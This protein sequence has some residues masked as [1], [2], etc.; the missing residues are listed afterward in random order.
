[1]PSFDN[2]NPANEATELPVNI[3]QGNLEAMDIAKQDKLSLISEFDNPNLKA[4]AQAE[5]QEL[6]ALEVEKIWDKQAIL[7][8]RQEYKS[9]M[10]TLAV[11]V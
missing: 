10:D 2:P 5:L 7:K 8:A 9:D 4:L 6:E 11:I 1:M 3:T